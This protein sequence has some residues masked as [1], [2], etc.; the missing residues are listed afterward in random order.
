ME[1][2]DQLTDNTARLVAVALLL[3][4]GGCA[5]APDQRRGMGDGGQSESMSVPFAYSGIGVGPS[6]M[7]GVIELERGMESR[8][9]SRAIID[10][11]QSLQLAFIE[12]TPVGLDTLLPPK[13]S[14]TTDVLPIE[15]ASIEAYNA[16]APARM[17][18]PIDRLYSVQYTGEYAVVDRELRFNIAVKLFQRGA[19]SAARPYARDYSGAYFIRQLTEAIRTKLIAATAAMPPSS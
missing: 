19:A 4:L 5:S 11:V 13:K 17:T 1:G 9:A 16:N 18:V 2:D 6:A 10:A 7:A 3:V 15:R 12:P 8:I 14:W